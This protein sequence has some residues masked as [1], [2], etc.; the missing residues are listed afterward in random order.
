MTAQ[1]IDHATLVKLIDAGT[2]RT[3][4][5]IG[6]TGGWGVIVSCGKA[7]RPL[8]AQRGKLRLFSKLDTVVTYL[9]GVGIAR[10]NVDTLD[11]DPRGARRVRPDRAQALKHAHKAAAYDKWFR[12][13]VQ[14]SLEDLR[15]SVP[16]E[17]VAARWARR[18]VDLAKKA[19]MKAGAKA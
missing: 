4:R 18:R 2:V 16:H 3:A 13:Q 15:P 11:Y 8:A 14:A 6:R 12:A 17:A 9:K 1:T 10:F 7:I 19:R 5:V